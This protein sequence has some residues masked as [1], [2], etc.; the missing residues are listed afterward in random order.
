MKAQNKYLILTGVKKIEE[1]TKGGI[2]VPDNVEDK[3]TTGWGDVYEVSE[4][5]AYSKGQRVIFSKY[6]PVQFKL[7]ETIYLA[8]KEED[9]IA[10]L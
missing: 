6:I 10:V 4:G 7:D 9:V 5:S 1:V 8:I 2:I 3:D